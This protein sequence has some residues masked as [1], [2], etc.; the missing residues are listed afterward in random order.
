MKGK[1]FSSGSITRNYLIFSRSQRR[2]I[3]LFC[4]LPL[5][6]IIFSKTSIFTNDESSDEP[7]V[8]VKVEESLKVRNL[9]YSPKQEEASRNNNY[10]L[11]THATVH[12]NSAHTQTSFTTGNL[13]NFDPNTATLDQLLALG[14]REK[15]ALNIIRYREKGGRFR[16]PED[17]K[18]MYSLTQ[19]EVT[20]LIPYANIISEHAHSAGVEDGKPS[21]VA[22]I[23]VVTPV[24]KPKPIATL[25]VDINVAD[26]L[27]WT[28]LPGIGAKRAS[29]ILKFRSRLGG[30]VSV[31]QVG[32]TF[33]LPDSVFQRIKPS[34]VW[35]ANTMEQLSLNECTEA[36]LKSHPY[37]P[38]QLAK[39]IV[40]Y[41]SQHGP[42]KQVDD[43]LK[44]HA[45]QKDW[46]EKVRPY[47]KA[48]S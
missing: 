20:R 15:A 2:A 42:Y 9:N 24:L 39:V 4:L 19:D 38:W 11:N 40:A 28:L 41:R 10:S 33:G 23:E 36:Q 48:G 14:L 18:K 31:D 12:S 7:F 27:T 6:V 45:V 47:L 21:D 29:A 44:I 34:L 17:L 26:S 37:I 30:F 22:S 3:L 32:E 13:T 25:L 35:K 46:F 43:L 8:A 16:K 5:V 1:T